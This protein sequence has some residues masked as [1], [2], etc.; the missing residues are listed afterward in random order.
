LIDAGG[1]AIGTPVAAAP[2]ER[3]PLRAALVVLATMALLAG[4]GIVL[5]LGDLIAGD[6]ARPATT[7]LTAPAGGGWDAPISFGALA[8]R[9]VERTA[10]TT[11]GAGHAIEGDRHD[12]VRVLLT[13]GNRRARAVA[14]SPGQF[15][16][17]LEGSGTSVPPVRPNP[18]PGGIAPAETVAQRLT[19]VV[20][21][22]RTAFA[23][24]FDDLE[25][26]KPLTIALGS[27]PRPAS[28]GKE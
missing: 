15:R 24:L 10:G 9:R 7:S 23:L 5:G 19:F 12:E 20:P 4:G 25:R 21:A 18:P 17:R 14:F 28:R 13:L 2:A 16:L 22:R 3:P 26:S 1:S 8:V 27:L 11:H 6:H